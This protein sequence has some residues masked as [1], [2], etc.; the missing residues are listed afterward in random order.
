MV[1]A[2][3]K[4]EMQIPTAMHLAACLVTVAF[5][6]KWLYSLI[7]SLLTKWNAEPNAEP[8]ALGA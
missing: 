6:T 5:Q 3:L 8:N 7:V 2:G 4:Y 1:T